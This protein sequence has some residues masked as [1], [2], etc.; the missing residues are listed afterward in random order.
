MPIPTW[1]T[2]DKR[3]FFIKNKLSFA[4]KINENQIY[5]Q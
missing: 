4:K 5:M 2:G 3:L 1:G